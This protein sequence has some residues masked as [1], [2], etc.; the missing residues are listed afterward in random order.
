MLQVVY[1]SAARISF[2]KQDLKFLEETATRRN[3][4]RGITGILLYRAET[5]FQVIEGPDEV[6]NQTFD[7]IRAND[8]HGHIRVLVRRFVHKREF[9]GWSMSIIDPDKRLSPGHNF[10][11]PQKPLP[12]LA[13]SPT[14]ATR[15]MHLFAAGFHHPLDLFETRPETPDRPRFEM[16]NGLYRNEKARLPFRR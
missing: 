4:L 6:V 1:V 12:L 7:M 13:S 8:N 11:A 14:A 5:F 16:P 9:E 3:E 10:A 15:H 2:S